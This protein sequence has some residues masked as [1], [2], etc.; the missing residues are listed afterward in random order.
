MPRRWRWAL[1]SLALA[2]ALRYVIRFPW[3]DTWSTLA[4]ADRGML[5]A[6]AAVNLLSLACKASAW[7][8]LLTPLVAVRG[9]TTQA[10]TFVGAAV[11]SISI[12]VTGEASRLHLVGLWD[13]VPAGTAA[14]TIAVSRLVEAAALGVFLLAF[15][16]IAMTAGGGGPPDWRVVAGAGALAVGGLVLIRRLR[17][18]RATRPLAPLAFATAAWGLQWATYYCSIA[19]THIPVTPSS[20]LFALLLSNFGGIFRLTPGNVGI[21]QGAVVLGLSP[22]GVPAPQAVAAGLVLQAVQVLPVLLIGVAILGPYGLKGV[23]FSGEAEVSASLGG[24]R[25]V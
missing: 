24:G 19:A 6:A 3:L 1:G 4:S 25:G 5:I 21:V 17:W 22:S 15:V 18:V 8:L 20:S 11:S 7:H 10:A 14:R 12:G 23:L 9:R 2:V 13:G 16:S